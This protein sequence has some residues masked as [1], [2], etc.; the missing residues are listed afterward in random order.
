MC[1]DRWAA[2]E[3]GEA[4]AS[5]HITVRPW[6]G[7]VSVHMSR[8]NNA[9]P[10]SF[11]DDYND[12]LDKRTDTQTPSNPQPKPAISAVASN[13]ALPSDVKICSEENFK[14]T[15]KVFNAMGSCYKISKAQDGDLW[16]H[17]RS[18]LQ[19]DG[20]VCLYFSSYEYINVGFY[21][22]T[23][24][25]WMMKDPVPNDFAIRMG[26]VFCTTSYD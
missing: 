13:T 12:F 17:A 20:A 15:C 4:S 6:Y 26:S 2:A 23:M 9:G 11:S 18:I 7:E 1:R 16:Y 21:I 8:G 19:W 10:D 22:D 3:A 25:H 14:G 24:E 5:E